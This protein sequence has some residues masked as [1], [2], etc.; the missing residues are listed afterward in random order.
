MSSSAAAESAAHAVGASPHFVALD[1]RLAAV[2]V[3]QDELRA[4]AHDAV[5]ALRARK[6]RNV[7][8]LTGDHPEASRVIADLLGLRHHYAE[9]LPEDKARL[10][11]EL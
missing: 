3:L 11:R 10:I 9:L 4:D 7:I 2:L 1:G 5:Q 6:M 8:L